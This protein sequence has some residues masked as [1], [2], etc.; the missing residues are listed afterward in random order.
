MDEQKIEYKRYSKLAYIICALFL[1]QLGIHSF[2][3]KKPVQGILFIIASI[4]GYLTVVVMVGYLI[5][6]VEF[7]IIII[8]IILAALKPADKY[9]N[10][11]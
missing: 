10:I 9:G 7:L 2:I 4:I 5:L 6:F 11:E 3:A 1:G 8:Q